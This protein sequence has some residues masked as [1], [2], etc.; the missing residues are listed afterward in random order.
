MTVVWDVPLVVETDGEYASDP[1]EVVSCGLC[2]AVTR[3]RFHDCETFLDERGR[4]FRTHAGSL[5]TDPEEIELRRRHGI[6][7]REHRLA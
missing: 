5:Q 6:Y 1:R 4:T 2:G 3:A 7:W